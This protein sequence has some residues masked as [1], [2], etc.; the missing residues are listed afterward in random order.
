M[1]YKKYNFCYSTCILGA[2]STRQNS[3]VEDNALPHHDLVK[4]NVSESLWERPQTS[5][6]N[7]FH[8]LLVCLHSQNNY[9]LIKCTKLKWSKTLT[10]DHINN[11]TDYNGAFLNTFVKIRHRCDKRKRYEREN[12]ALSYILFP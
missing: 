6:S 12:T 8:K 5:A 3:T 1:F 10:R 9:L 4:Q 2:S 7:S 11:H